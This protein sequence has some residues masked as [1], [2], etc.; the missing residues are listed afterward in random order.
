MEGGKTLSRALLLFLAGFVNSAPARAQSQQNPVYE[1][2]SIKPSQPG[3]RPSIQSGAGGRLNATNATL[4]ALVGFAYN[5]RDYQISNGPNWL[6]SAGYDIIA[7]PEHPVDPTPDN[8]DYF[9]QMLQGLLADRFKLTLSRQ[10]KELPVY[11]LLVARDGPKLK[12][13]EKWQKGA[14]MRIHGGAGQMIAEK[15]TMALLAQ[16][17]ANI[18]SRFVVDK[19]GL[20]GYYDFKLEWMPDE[21]GQPGTGDRPSI[22]TA[23]QEQLGLKL[24]SQ[25]GPV[26]ILVIDHAEKASA[27]WR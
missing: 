22:F 11:A 6:D 12:E 26:D 19:T 5:V 10:K 2:A 21:I 13:V 7:T 17:L 16:T 9:R 20:T 25:K 8:I 15:V 18:A 14:D 24:D 4:K 3:G 27:N 23:L 1:V